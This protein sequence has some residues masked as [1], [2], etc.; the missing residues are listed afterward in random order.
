MVKRH[1][2]VALVNVPVDHPEPAPRRLKRPG[3]PAHQRRLVLRRLAD[4]HH[5]PEGHLQRVRAQQ[6]K[7]PS[8]RVMLVLGHLQIRATPNTPCRICDPLSRW[9]S[10]SRLGDIPE[11]PQQQAA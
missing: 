10:R 7:R 9:L 4:P 5:V 1:A 2:E 8:Q 6:V 3:V 11:Y